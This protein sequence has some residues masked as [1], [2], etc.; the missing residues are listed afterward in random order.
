M[1]FLNEYISGEDFERYNLASLNTARPRSG[2][3]EPSP[4]TAWTIDRDANT[5]LRQFCADAK[6]KASTGATTAVSVWDFYWRG[7]LTQ[8]KLQVLEAGGDAGQ[9]CWSRS[10]LVEIEMPAE[11]VALQWQI[12]RDLRAA[13]NAYKDG[14]V[15]SKASSFSCELE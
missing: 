5:W 13:L 8:V 12:K 4:A 2:S 11:M 14:G 10:R 6:L 9:H 3:A 1:A 7:A 15:L